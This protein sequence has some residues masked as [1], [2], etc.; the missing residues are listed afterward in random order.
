[1]AVK[2]KNPEKHGEKIQVI[3]EENRPRVTV[4]GAA[5]T[6]QAVEDMGAKEAAR[7]LM[8]VRREKQRIKELDDIE[9]A[10]K[11]RILA[12]Y[13]SLPPEDRDRLQIG[14]AGT[15]TYKAPTTGER[16]R[17][18]EA[19]LDDLNPAQIRASYVPDVKVLRQMLTAEQRAK[20]LEEVRRTRSSLVVTDRGG[21]L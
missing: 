14:Q 5:A 21:E 13:E 10:A 18:L 20:H 15:I 16:V 1:M 19:L 7:V 4:E 9:E 6:R 11:A 8:H 17:D 12:Y 3:E 2:I